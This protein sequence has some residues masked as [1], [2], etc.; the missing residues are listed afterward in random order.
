MP[1]CR[2]L[3][4]LVH[5]LLQRRQGRERVVGPASRRVARG[6]QRFENRRLVEGGEQQVVVGRERAALLPQPGE[7]GLHELVGAPG[8]GLLHAEAVG[9]LLDD[10]GQDR[11]DGPAVEPHRVARDLVGDGPVAFPL[12]HVDHR[13]GDDVLREGADDDR[14]AEVLADP[15]RLR[16]HLL[17]PVAHADVGKLGVQV[18]DHAARDLVLVELGVMALVDAQR[19]VVTLGQRDE[20]VRHLRE[21]VE[22]EP[23]PVSEVAEMADEILGRR[24]RV[25]PGHG[26]DGR[27]QHVDA[28]RDRLE[29]AEL[30]QP[31]A[32]VGV[33]LQ[34]HV[35]ADGTADRRNQC[36]DAV[37]REQAARVLDDEGV[38]PVADDLRRDVGVVFVRVD[39][40]QGVGEPGAAVETGRLGRRDGE[41][42][43]PDVA[44]R[45]VEGMA[46]HPVGGD[47]PDGQV[48]DVVGEEL[49]GEQAL[50]A[51]PDVERR[52]RAALRHQAHTL[53]GVFPQVAD[54]DVEDRATL[55]VYPV[56]A[57][58]VHTRGE[59]HDHVVGDARRPQ[60]LRGVAHRN[61]DEPDLL[62]GH[63]SDGGEP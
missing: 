6:E 29:V 42:D 43:V 60:R 37:G 10:L 58:L 13:L 20:V 45:V 54:A 39:R 30:R 63:S 14:I 27:V 21:V 19:L 22:V 1:E 11:S 50:A 35:R 33:E 18:G 31:A 26:A 5:E 7:P 15:H 34:R 57:H 61:V 51:G 25:G 41:L 59:G 32:A 44:Q 38:D 24:Q 48:D 47:A 12:R 23:D 40:T 62:H 49:E 8:D 9:G 28:E 56:E 55:E 52:P 16:Q 17:E 2:A 46:A 36:A 4:D 3:L 53:P